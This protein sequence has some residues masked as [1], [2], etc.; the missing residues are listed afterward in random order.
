MELEQAA[1]ARA[2]ESH[3]L[4]VVAL[5]RELQAKTVDMAAVQVGL[6][7]GLGLR[8]G[9]GLGLGSRVRRGGRAGEGC[10]SRSIKFNFILPLTLHNHTTLP[11]PW[12]LMSS[13]PRQIR[14][15]GA[16]EE[17]SEVQRQLVADLERQLADA[18][19]RLD[20]TE[21]DRNVLLTALEAH[22]AALEAKVEAAV[23]ERLGRYEAQIKELEQQKADAITLQSVE[24]VRVVAMD[25]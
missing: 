8:L 14:L 7:S 4:E 16:A 10:E 25:A 15:Q 17:V 13:P 19:L 3:G 9:L 1:R 5:Q 11:A 22:S 20:T 2:Q 12:P 21:R 6:G 18:R 24:Q 23:V